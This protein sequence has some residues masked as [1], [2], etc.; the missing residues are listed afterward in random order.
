CRAAPSATSLHDALPI[1]QEGRRQQLAGRQAPG[2]GAG[3]GGGVGRVE[4]VDVEVDVD[5]VDRQGEAVE[6]LDQHVLDGAE[7]DLGG[8]DDRPEEHTSELQSPDHIVC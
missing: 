2:T 8:G 5:V 4:D 3:A 7:A 1:G 6:G